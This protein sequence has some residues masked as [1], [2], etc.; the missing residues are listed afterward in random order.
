MVNQAESPPPGA[1][2]TGPGLDWLSGFFGGLQNL[3]S[4]GLVSPQAM[5]ATV[6]QLNHNLETLQG[7]ME[8]IDRLNANLESLAPEIK[9]FTDA[10]TGFAD[11]MWPAP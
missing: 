3:A 6:Q 1:A 4:S 10:L 9:R 7:G 11:R 5:M 8:S 2:P